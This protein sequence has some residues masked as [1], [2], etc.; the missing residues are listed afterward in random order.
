VAVQLLDVEATTAL[1]VT[2]L[3]VV[4]AWIQ[5]HIGLS[6]SSLRVKVVSYALLVLEAPATDGCLSLVQLIAVIWLLESVCSVVSSFE[7]FVENS[8]V[9]LIIVD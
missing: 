5:C 8:S 7:D 4:V 2:E 6:V 3:G 9:V 1:V